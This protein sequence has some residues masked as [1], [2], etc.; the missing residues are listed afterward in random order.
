MHL[1]QV[2]MVYD[3]SVSL[4]EHPDG[5]GQLGEVLGDVTLLEV[6]QGGEDY[7]HLYKFEIQNL[8]N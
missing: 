4:L 5:G 3:E 8:V 2:E 7:S 1:V 6:L